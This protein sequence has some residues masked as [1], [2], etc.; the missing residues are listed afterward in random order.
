VDDCGLGGV[1]TALFGT[2]LCCAVLVQPS[3]L[4]L[5][6]HKRT[7]L[8]EEL[9]TALKRVILTRLLDKSQHPVPVIHEA[10]LFV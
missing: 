9:A 2:E 1:E 10:V 6:S 8:L 7:A 5:L 3:V 4:P